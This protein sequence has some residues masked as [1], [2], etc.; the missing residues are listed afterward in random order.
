M[1]ASP[2]IY[3]ASALDFAGGA[4]YNEHHRKIIVK[5]KGDRA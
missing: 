5:S 4:T 2:R 3:P 1:V